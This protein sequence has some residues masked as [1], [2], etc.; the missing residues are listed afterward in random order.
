MKQPH[1]SQIGWQLLKRNLDKLT[2]V[3]ADEGYDWELLCHKLRSEGIKPVIKYPEFG[4]HGVANYALMDDTTYHQRSTIE[5]TFFALR[6]RYGEVIRARTWYGQ[7]RELVLTCAVRNVE[8]S[9]SN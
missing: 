6:R 8:L 3:T 7:F 4:L 9:L 5:S 2:K 1:D